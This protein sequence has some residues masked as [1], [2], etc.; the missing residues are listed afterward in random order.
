MLGEFF[1]DEPKGLIPDIKETYPA[2]KPE[3]K[4][5][6]VSL[7]SEAVDLDLAVKTLMN[8]LEYYS[9]EEI[10]ILQLWLDGEP[11]RAISVQTGIPQTTISL[12]IKTMRESGNLGFAFESAWASKYPEYKRGGLN[13]PDPDSLDPEN[14]VVYSLKCFAD[15]KINL[16]FAVKEIA[17]SELK[18]MLEGWT[19]FLV[20]L[21]MFSKTIRMY[22]IEQASKQ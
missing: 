19:L 12:K 11:Q 13:T 9:P 16:A 4:G 7:V 20:I 21:E 10:R 3:F 14:K 8:L 15:P 22:R 6:S 2:I 1:L 18:L 17:E 5:L